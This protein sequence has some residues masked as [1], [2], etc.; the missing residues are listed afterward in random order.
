M[1]RASPMVIALLFVGAFGCSHDPGMNRG[2]ADDTGCNG[3]TA[4]H[5]SYVPTAIQQQIDL[6]SARSVHVQSYRLHADRYRVRACGRITLFYEVVLAR[7]GEAVLREVREYYAD[8]GTLIASSSED[9]SRQLPTSGRYTR[10]TILPIPAAAPAGRY[11]V[12]SRLLVKK[13]RAA[14]FVQLA[15]AATTFYIE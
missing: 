1:Q 3:Q 10:S 15:R 2:A 8:D 6:P 4:S 12:V 14:R 9:V 7:Q 11:R 13:S 5:S